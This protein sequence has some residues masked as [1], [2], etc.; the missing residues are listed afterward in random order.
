L[1]GVA[2]RAQLFF[3]ALIDNV[4]RLSGLPLD[5][6]DLFLEAYDAGARVHNNS[7]GNQA[8]SSYMINSEEVDDFVHA[9]PDMVI[10]IAACNEGN[11]AATLAKRGGKGWVDWLSICA[12]AS[13]KNAI[14]V[15]ASRSDRKDGPNAARTFGQLW[16]DRFPDPPISNALVLGR[17]RLSRGLQQPWPMQRSPDKARRRRAGNRHRLDQIVEGADDEFSSALIRPARPPT[18]TTPRR[19]NQHGCSLCDG[20]CGSRAAILR[21][22]RTRAKRG[23]GEGDA[24]QRDG[25]AERGRFR[26]SDRRYAELSS[27]ARPNRRHPISSEPE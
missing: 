7:W 27:R 1:K 20:L 21:A 6:N 25:L 4:G 22:A 12:P 9:H 3:Q 26:S 19:R 17:C 8:A 10:V 16:P 11:A 18:R 13:S 14:T 24:R 5:L 15:G 2:P 23:A